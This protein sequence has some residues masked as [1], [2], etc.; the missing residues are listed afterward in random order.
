MKPTRREIRAR[1]GLLLLSVAA[2]L[3][4]WVFV[5]FRCAAEAPGLGPQCPGQPL[6]FVTKE[7]LQD[8]LSAST[9][10]PG[11][12]IGILVDGKVVRLAKVLAEGCWAPGGQTRE[13][14]IEHCDNG[15]EPDLIVLY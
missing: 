9:L 12:K 7:Q 15:Q 5:A 11:T 1:R 6:P 3:A 4:F 14:G 10:P 2:F 8:A 13:Y